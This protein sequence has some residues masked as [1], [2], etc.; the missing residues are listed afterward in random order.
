MDKAFGGKS[1]AEMTPEDR[2][3]AMTKMREEMKKAGIELPSRGERKGGAEGKQGEGGAGEG[4]RGGQGG[5]RMPALAMGSSGQQFSQRELD[6]AQLPP[7]PEESSQLEVLMRPGLLAD[8][9]IVV[10]KIPNAI[11]I[12]AQAIFEKEGKSIVYVKQGG[13]FIARVVKPLKRS[14]STMIISEG[15]QPGEEVALQD[16]DAKPSERKGGKG[17][18]GGGGAPAMPMGMGKK[19]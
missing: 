1:P 19:G 6:T 16:P 15:L 9:E 14:E 18:G 8:V 12:P 13:K 5:P 7:P 17:A 3:A 2:Q 10:E 4:R 11:H